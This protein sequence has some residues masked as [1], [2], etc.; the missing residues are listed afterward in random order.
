M[1]RSIVHTV[2]CSAQRIWRM[3]RSLTGDDAYDRYCRH[4]RDR[5]PGQPSLSRSDFY[6]LELRRKWSGINRCC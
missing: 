2:R 3:L 5:H 1:S 6:D 4:V